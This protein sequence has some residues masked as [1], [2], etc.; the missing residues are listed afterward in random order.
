MNNSNGNNSGNMNNGSASNTSANT[1]ANNS[2]TTNNSSSSSGRPF[3]IPIEL[4]T[5]ARLDDLQRMLRFYPSVGAQALLE[6]TEGVPSRMGLFDGVVA[7]VAMVLPVCAVT[8]MGNSGGGMNGSGNSNNSS[9]SSNTSSSAAA[10]SAANSSSS[11][12][13][14]ASAS[15]AAAAAASAAALAG[16]A[17]SMLLNVLSSSASGYPP[18][19]PPSSSSNSS[20]SSSSA[21]AT[22][23]SA[24]PSALLEL[25]PRGLVSLLEVVFYALSIPQAVLPSQQGQLVTALTVL[26]KDAHLR[27]LAAAWPAV[28]GGGRAGAG[29]LASRVVEL[30]QKLLIPGGALGSGGGGIDGEGGGG[31]AGIGG[32]AGGNSSNSNINNNNFFSATGHNYANSDP[33][34]LQQQQQ[35]QAMN[36]ET[37]LKENVLQSLVRC[38]DSLEAEFLA[39]PVSLISRLVLIASPFAQQFVAMGGLAPSTIQKLLDDRNPAPVLIDTLLVVSQLAR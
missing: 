16:A 34:F 1:T 30:Y 25:S 22:H 23:S 19:P 12:N 15:A 26:I 4:M 13:S 5:P 31:G 17:V 38:V 18:P 35:Q 39:Q 8:L 33:H 28:Y 27:A 3:P 21:A 20:S 36:Q 29:I 37:L 2:N 6:E 7:L 9:N 14:P 11:S 32:G 24:H 10:S